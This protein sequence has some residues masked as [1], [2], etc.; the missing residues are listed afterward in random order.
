MFTVIHHTYLTQCLVTLLYISTG[1][2]LLLIEYVGFIVTLVTTVCVGCV[3]YLRYKEPHRPRP[4][5]VR[6]AVL[7]LHYMEPNIPRPIEVRL[8]VHYLR[9]KKPYRPKPI[10]VS[11]SKLSCSE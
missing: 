5:K 8:S 11:L 7:Y 3:L 9:Y 2:A 10:E 1:S 4:I 6:L